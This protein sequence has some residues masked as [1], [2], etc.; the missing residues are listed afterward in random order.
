MAKEL[1]FTIY[2]MLIPYA[3]SILYVCNPSWIEMDLS[4]RTN[5]RAKL[6][7]HLAK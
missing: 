4:Q 3:E 1:S 2:K 5:L 7:F 6:I